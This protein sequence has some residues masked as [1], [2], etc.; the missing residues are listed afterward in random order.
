MDRLTTNKDVSE[1][2]MY[3][4][5]H[6][7]CYAKEGWAR[8]RDYEIDIDARD[9]ARDLLKRYADGDDAFTD[10]EDFGEYM[11][12]A[13]QYGMN[14]I[15]GRIA[16][17]YR[18]LWAMADLRERL[19]YYEDL[20]EQGKLL[21]LPCAV[22]D[23][24]YR[25]HK[26]TKLSP[27]RTYECRVVGVKQEC[28]TFSVKLYANINEETYSIWIDDWFDRCQIGYEFFLTKEEAEAALKEMSE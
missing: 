4:L 12:D 16:L 25:V 2:S 17:F 13:M 22:G 5:A 6:N 1:M 3:E 27:D 8:Y 7:S 18:N 20:E 15:E 24:V 28:N 14:D 9:L 26:G 23:T 19:K 11:N 21:K 10:D